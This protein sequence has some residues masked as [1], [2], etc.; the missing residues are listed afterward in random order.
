MF[1]R[2]SISERLQFSRLRRLCFPVLIGLCFT[3]LTGSLLSRAHG[4]FAAQY[5]PAYTGQLHNK[6]A[7]PV[8]QE[9]RGRGCVPVR[10]GGTLGA[11]RRV[12]QT[13]EN[14]SL[15]VGQGVPPRRMIRS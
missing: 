6:I 4:V 12:W 5:S 13:S 9:K 8:W 7:L 10:M 3:V 1:G 14:H 2:K 15:P 11:K